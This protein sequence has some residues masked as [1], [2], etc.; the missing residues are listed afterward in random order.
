MGF[1]DFTRCQ[2]ELWWHKKAEKSCSGNTLIKNPV[3]WFLKPWNPRPTARMLGSCLRGGQG[4]QSWTRGPEK[5]DLF[6]S[7]PPP[8]P[9]PNADN[10]CHFEDEKICGYT[11]DLT[12]NFD[13]TRQNALT[14][15]P[16]RSPNTGPPTDI[17]GTPEGENLACF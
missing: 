17:S 3:A 7:P 8:T 2:K 14:Q 6:V 10:T 15:N 12:D 5:I 9:H 11:Q 13:W 1:L 16:K 4:G